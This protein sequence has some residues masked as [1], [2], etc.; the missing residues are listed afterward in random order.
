MDHD[1]NLLI[2]EPSVSVPVLSTAAGGL[3]T[4]PS[5]KTHIV[6]VSSDGKTKNGYDF[7]GSFQIVGVGQ[8]AVYAIMTLL[9]T[10]P[11]SITRNLVA[12]RV[13]AGTL[14]ATLP[15]VSAGADIKLSPGTTP[16][17]VDRIAVIDTKFLPVLSPAADPYLSGPASLAHTILLFTSDGTTFVANMNNPISTE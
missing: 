7:K 8:N 16:G 14:P 10:N 9:S 17:D 12:L 11:L 1:G 5:S 4:S 6:V 13:V 3:V 2:L 15:S